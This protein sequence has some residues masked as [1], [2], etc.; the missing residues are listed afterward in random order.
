MGGL[1]CKSQSVYNAFLLWKSKQ[2]SWV[3]SFTS[4]DNDDELPESRLEHFLADGAP[5]LCPA[6]TRRIGSRIAA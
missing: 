3:E 4:G 6:L 1:Q 5:R 2:K